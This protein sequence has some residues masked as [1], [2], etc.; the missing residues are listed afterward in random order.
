MHAFPQI[1]IEIPLL[2]K[3]II[4]GFN[5][6]QKTIII[7][8]PVHPGNSGGPVVMVT[9][10]E[11]GTTLFSIIGIMTQWIPYEQVWTNSKTGQKKSEFTNSG[12]SVV[13]P[14][15]RILEIL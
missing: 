12:Y 4:S 8:C 5:R 15:D 13:V 1:N 14:I 7:D 3:G 2:R 9:H 11:N 6:K 10:I